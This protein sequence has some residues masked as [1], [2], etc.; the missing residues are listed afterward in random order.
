MQTVLDLSFT[1]ARQYFL[2]SENY[3]NMSL[4]KYIEFG[5]ILSFVQKQVKNKELEDILAKPKV[6]PSSFEGVNYKILKKKD[7]MC[8]YRS[9]QL[10]N[11]FLYYLLVKKMTTE[12]AWN[13][14]L[15]RFK[16]NLRSTN[17]SCWYSKSKIRIRQ[18]ASSCRCIF[19]VGR[20]GTKKL[21]IGFTI[22]IYV[23]NRYY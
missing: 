20:N 23:G 14:I 3:C 5:D 13:E 15:T 2:E 19:L 16:K 7:A 1:K 12:S 10:A 22:S 6:M 21:R 9:M 17:R 18:I 8:S 4:P 11:P